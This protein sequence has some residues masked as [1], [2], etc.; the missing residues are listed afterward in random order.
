MSRT[1]VIII[2]GFVVLAVFLLVGAG[3]G[4]RG[5]RRATEDFLLVWLALVSGNMAVGVIDEGY[6]VVEEIPFWIL[7]FVPAAAV[8]VFVRYLVRDERPAVTA[9]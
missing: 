3:F 6:G 8:A 2:V 9:G 7:N 5:I 1:T 4:R